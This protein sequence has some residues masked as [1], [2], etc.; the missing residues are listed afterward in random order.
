M[1]I[2]IIFILSF[3]IDYPRIVAKLTTKKV[4]FCGFGLPVRIQD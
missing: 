2:Y 1:Y 3:I 4:G